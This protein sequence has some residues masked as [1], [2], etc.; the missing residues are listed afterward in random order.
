MQI[1][2]YQSSPVDEGDNLPAVLK[3]AYKALRGN[4]SFGKQGFNKQSVNLNLVTDNIDGN[5]DVISD[6]GLADTQFTVTHNLNRQPIGYFVIR[7]SKA[8]SFYDSG[9]AWTTTQIFLKCSG[10]NVAATIFVI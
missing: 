4:I 5:F 2:K 7:Q 6:T 3:D 8:G 9:T 10:A 1:R